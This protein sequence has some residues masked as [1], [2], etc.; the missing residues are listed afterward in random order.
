MGKVKRKHLTAYE[1]NLADRRGAKDAVELA[2][3]IY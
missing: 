1:R 3:D 2:R